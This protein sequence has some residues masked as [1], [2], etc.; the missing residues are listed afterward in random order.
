MST[1]YTCYKCRVNPT[2]G[3]F[4][5]CPTCLQTEAIIEQG[6]ANRRALKDQAEKEHTARVLGESRRQSEEMYERLRDERSERTYSEPEELGLFG[7][8]VLVPLGVAMAC[9]SLYVLYWIAGGIFGFG[10]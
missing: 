7:K 2:H 5:T 6:K 4:A 10:R 3:M 1:Q 9:G 8:I